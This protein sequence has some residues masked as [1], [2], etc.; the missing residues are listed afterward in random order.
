MYVCTST[1]TDTH[2]HTI[3]HRDNA[4]EIM[5]NASEGAKAYKH[6]GWILNGGI[7]NVSWEWTLNYI[8]KEQ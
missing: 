1:Q 8:L 4:I 6:M 7:S 2:T 5:R 3:I